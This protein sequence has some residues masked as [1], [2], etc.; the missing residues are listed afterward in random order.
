MDLFSL[1]TDSNLYL[2]FA[3]PKPRCQ[4]FSPHSFSMFKNTVQNNNDACF[5]LLHNN[6]KSLKRN[7]ENFQVHLL[8]ELDYHFSVIGVTE[9]KITSINVL[10]FNPNLPNCEFEYAPTPLFCGIYI[11]NNWV[12]LGVKTCEVFLCL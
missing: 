4:Y 5:S 2:N 7:L 8:D 1:N 3:F 10:D 9:T 6:V 11:S 12:C